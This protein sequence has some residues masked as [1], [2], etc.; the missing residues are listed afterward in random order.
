M[1]KE[2]TKIHVKNHKDGSKTI[3]TI[4]TNHKG[5]TTKERKN[6]AFGIITGILTI[7]INIAKIFS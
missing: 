4:V 3:T 6:L 5:R 2:K 1:T 7:G